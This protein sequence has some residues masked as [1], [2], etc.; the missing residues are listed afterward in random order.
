LSNLYQRSARVTVWRAEANKFFSQPGASNAIVIE[1]LRVTFEIEHTTEKEPNKCDLTIT[2]ASPETRAFLQRKP[3]SV[4]IEAGYA[5]NFH[6]LFVGD[7]RHGSSQL[8]GT[9]WITKMQVADGDRAYR[10]ARVSESFRAG[11]RAIDTLQ[12]IASSLQIALPK[13][14]IDDPALRSQ[15][16]NGATV[17][18][19]A[20]DVMTKILEPYGYTWS[21]QAGRLVVLRDKDLANSLA[22]VVDATNGMIG[23]PETADPEK[24]GKPPTTTIRTLL[25][26]RLLPGHKVQLQS[27]AVSGLFKVRKVKHTGDT[28][29]GDF[30]TEIEATPI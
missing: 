20:R 21:I 1:N 3:L 29:G 10:H 25:D 28:H 16:A 18:G 11:T 23:R 13:N 15:F 4:R 22:Y 26:S 6:Q 14:V 2:N 30:Q 9:E 5:G 7:L 19:N 27:E 17:H 12:K 24:P 8:E